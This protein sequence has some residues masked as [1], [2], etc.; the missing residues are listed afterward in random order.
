P[1]AAAETSAIV[2]RETGRITSTSFSWTSAKLHEIA[3]PVARFLSVCFSGVSARATAF[4]CA[5][6]RGRGAASS[7]IGDATAQFARST[8]VALAPAFAWMRTNAYAVAPSLAE[9]GG[10]GGGVTREVAREGTARVK[11]ALASALPKRVP[12]TVP[13][14]M[15]TGEPGAEGIPAV[16]PQGTAPFE[17]STRGEKALSL[18]RH[19]G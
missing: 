10:K 8:G 17:V 2:A 14:E 16:A 1:C 7:I 11:T 4:S 12:L 6:G 3:P 13:G 18:P 9:R 5:A 15:R 19:V